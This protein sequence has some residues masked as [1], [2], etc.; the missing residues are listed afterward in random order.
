MTTSDQ[1][2]RSITLHSWPPR[3]IVSLVP[4]QTE[5][6]YDLGLEEE[7]VGIT[8]FCVRPD[9]WFQSKT[10]IG[11]TK[12]LN[13][14]KI[15]AL[16]PDLIIGNMEENDRAQIETLAERFPV[17]MS[18]IRT[19]A[20]AYDMI[21]RVGE[22]TGKDREAGDL[23]Q[24]IQTGL[25][26]F[27]HPATVGDM[28]SAVYLI[29]RKPYMSAGG[30]TFIHEMMHVAGFENAFAHKNRYPEISPEELSKTRPDVI[31]LSSEPYPFA[32]KHINTI[33]D[34]C[35]GAQVI[36]VDGEIFSW[37]G[38]RL[39]HAGKYFRELRKSLNLA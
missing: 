16:Q 37:Y 28:P 6:L 36:L 30:D 20:D 23:V 14:P 39:L 26:D 33:R 18:D 3:R 22:L 7:M 9:T 21:R 31:L 19:L 8:K 25:T 2:N 5:L 27:R 12:T 1:L 32:E 10:R 35:P 4:S 15:A 29:W 38:S 17:W 34:L 24:K 11:G 13:I